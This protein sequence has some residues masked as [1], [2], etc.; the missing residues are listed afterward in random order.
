M[1]ASGENFRVDRVFIMLHIGHIRLLLD[2][3]LLKSN[4]EKTVDLI[5]KF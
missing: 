5:A 3:R 4:E 2:S 1:F